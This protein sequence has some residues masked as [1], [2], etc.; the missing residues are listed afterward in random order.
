MKVKGMLLHKDFQVH[1]P[2]AIPN[3]TASQQQKTSL[4]HRKNAYYNSSI[5]YLVL[6]VIRYFHHM[7]P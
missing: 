1:N 5:G 7:L 2:K 4:E 3:G 6:F